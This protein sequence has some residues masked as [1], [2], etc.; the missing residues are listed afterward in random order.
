MSA[1]TDAFG[2]RNRAFGDLSG[3]LT[4]R[5]LEA[6][7]DD[8]A[9]EEREDGDGGGAG[10]DDHALELQVGAGQGEKERGGGTGV[11]K[12]QAEDRYEQVFAPRSHY[13]T[14]STITT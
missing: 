2:A 6:G 5:S 3:K 9:G 13:S 4:V 8:I 10:A 14:Y 12:Q 11:E 1:A 7:P